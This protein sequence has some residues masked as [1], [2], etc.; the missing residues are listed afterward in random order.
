MNYA[1]H[2][3]MKIVPILNES[4]EDKAFISVYENIYLI[5]AKNDLVAWEEAEK[6]GRTLEE[7][8]SKV[9]WMGIESNLCFAGVRR[10]VSFSVVSPDPIHLGE[11]T[12][13]Q[14]DFESQEDFDSYL[15]G[16]SSAVKL[17]E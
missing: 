8:Q 3:V 1:A 11:L 17:L 10:L 4:R 7:N 5:S 14:I 2:L 15:V 9:I 13:L 12:Y 6:L 16:N